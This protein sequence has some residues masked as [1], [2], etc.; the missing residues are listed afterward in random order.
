MES[1]PVDNKAQEI[2]N[3]VQQVNSSQRMAMVT[4]EKEEI[5]ELGV[6]SQIRKLF[7]AEIAYNAKAD[8]IRYRADYNKILDVLQINI[9]IFIN[10]FALSTMMHKN[11]S[12]EMSYAYLSVVNDIYHLFLQDGYTWQR[13][14]LVGQLRHQSLKNVEVT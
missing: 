11:K 2:L 6:N 12:I 9:S 4:D 8:S 10:I 14:G 13:L 7:L 1:N 3:K 5:L